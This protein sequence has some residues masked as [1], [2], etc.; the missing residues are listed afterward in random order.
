MYELL[1]NY[2]NTIKPNNYFY[3]KAIYT[4]YDKGNKLKYESNFISIIDI[5]YK[6]YRLE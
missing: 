5:P 3:T 2:N 1:F 4:V 6:R